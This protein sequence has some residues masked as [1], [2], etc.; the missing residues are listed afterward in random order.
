MEMG[1]YGELY[2]SIQEQDVPDMRC[3]QQSEAEA[4]VWVKIQGRRV[5]SLQ[6]GEFTVQKGSQS[7]CHQHQS[8]Q[9]PPSTSQSLISITKV[10]D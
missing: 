8:H 6:S 9:R 7:T 2:R 4:P 5:D 1:F 10:I 3:L